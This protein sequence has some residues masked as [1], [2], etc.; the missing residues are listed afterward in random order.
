MF[1]EKSTHVCVTTLKPEEM[2]WSSILSNLDKNRNNIGTT[3]YEMMSEI[4][5]TA[6]SI[7]EYNVK[8]N[9]VQIMRQT[10]VLKKY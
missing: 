3:A 1:N 9:L 8:I 10:S 7:H 4:S 2:S 6:R 5:C